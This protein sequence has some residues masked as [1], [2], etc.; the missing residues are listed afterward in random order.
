MATKT[1]RF[2]LFCVVNMKLGL[3][4][5]LIWPDTGFSTKPTNI[6]GRY[7]TIIFYF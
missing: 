2:K 1:K 3:Y 5:I 4:R 6:S 7:F